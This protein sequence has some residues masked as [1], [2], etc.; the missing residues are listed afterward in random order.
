[1]K[2][3]ADGSFTGTMDRTAAAV[4]ASLAGL[5]ERDGTMSAV[6]GFGDPGNFV[7]KGRVSKANGDL[8][9]SFKYDWLGK[10]YSGSFTMGL[11]S[12]GG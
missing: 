9:S 4:S 1:M 7:I 6:A 10:E 2:V 3:G 11:Q 5:I 8:V 12:G